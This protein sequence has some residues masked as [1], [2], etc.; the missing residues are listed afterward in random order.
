[1][2]EPYLTAETLAEILSITPRAVRK[3]C[4][5][6]VYKGYMRELPSCGRRGYR[7]EISILHPSIP[8]SARRQWL[9]Q[10]DTNAYTIYTNAQAAPEI[11]PGTANRVTLATLSEP[12]RARCM[13]WHSLLESAERVKGQ[14]RANYLAAQGIKISTYWAIRKR[15]ID[16]GCY[17]AAIARTYNPAHAN[18]SV[19]APD[20]L[21]RFAAE[22]LRDSRPSVYNCH[23]IVMGY[24]STKDKAGFNLDDF[25]H[26]STFLRALERRYTQ[27]AIYLRRYGEYQ[28]RQKFGMHL[29]RDYS[30]ILAG[31]VWCSDHAQSDVAVLMP[32][33]TRCFPWYTPWIDVKSQKWL[34]W[35]IH[36]EAPNSDHILNAFYD[37]SITR[38]NGIVCSDAIIDNGKDYRCRDLAGG[39]TQIRPSLDIAETTSMFG[40]LK[41]KVH[42]AK[43]YNA[44]AKII[45]RTFSKVNEMFARFM[46]G[47][48]GPNVVQRPESLSAISDGALLTYDDYCEQFDRF[49]SEVLNR[50]VSNGKALAGRCPDEVW[51]AEY[52]AS[53]DQ[54][55]VRRVTPDAMAMFTCRTTNP[56]TIRGNGVSGAGLPCY[57]YADWMV[58]HIGRKVYL[59]RPMADA[60]APAYVFDAETKALLGVAD[61]VK[62]TAAI[63]MTEDQELTLREALKRQAEQKKAIAESARIPDID[64]SDTLE[65]RVAATRLINKSRG[66]TPVESHSEPSIIATTRAD[67][68][69]A[70]LKHHDDLGRAIEVQTPGKKKAR[71][72]PG[73][74]YERVGAANG[75]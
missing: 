27:A 43:P 22:Y 60:S 36:P 1:M 8:E 65:F 23:K 56:L 41:I 74:Y 2:F 28:Y 12:E 24:A 54:G 26:P 35:V 52:P 62:Q 75:Y 48:R 64:R 39:R 21:D 17:P 61:Q 58:A 73:L 53:C 15:W 68:D 40:E 29:D 33:G 51:D 42:F 19:I 50:E 13:T 32:D 3:N 47:Y 72:D 55:L 57:Y 46:P 44:Q 49:V 59:R 66:Y 69:L 5:R 38:G 31:Q 4:S 9:Q 30:A 70:N 20:L 11:D 45:E 14:T 25:P 63:C 18:V 71:I 34:G 7:Y 16:G 67:I 37:A 10:N 6:G